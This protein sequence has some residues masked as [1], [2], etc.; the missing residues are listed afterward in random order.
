MGDTAARIVGG[1]YGKTFGGSSRATP[2]RASSLHRP[3]SGIA[4]ADRSID[5]DGIG[6][7]RH[8]R[9]VRSS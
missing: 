1:G 9:S 2:G 6:G 4:A 7:L 5:G 3:D 8:R